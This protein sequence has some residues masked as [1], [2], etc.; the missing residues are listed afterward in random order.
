MKNYQG[1]LEM[2]SRGT[3]KINGFE[4][5]AS[6]LEN[7]LSCAFLQNYCCPQG[8]PRAP[9]CSLFGM[10]RAPILPF[11]ESLGLPWDPPGE[12]KRS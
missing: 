2:F 8:I 7:N 3:K 9:Y 5:Q 12:A 4:L 11:L 1:P 6:G 10:P